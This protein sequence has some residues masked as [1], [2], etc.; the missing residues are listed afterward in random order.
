M[1]D[2]STPVLTFPADQV[3]F[4]AGF[5][6]SYYPDDIADWGLIRL[7]RA[8]PDHEPLPIRRTGK[9]ADG[10]TLFMIG[11]PLGLPAKHAPGGYV[12]ESDAADYFITNLDASGGNSGSAVFDAESHVVEGILVAGDPVDLVYRGNCLVSSV[13]ADDE[14]MGEEVIRSSQFAHL[15]PPLSGSLGYSVEFGPAGN[16][17]SLG[18]TSVPR[19][20]VRDLLPGTRYSWRVTVQG[21]CGETVGPTWT[22]TTAPA[23]GPV[24]FRRGDLVEDGKIDLSDAIGVLGVLFSGDAAECADAADADGNGVLEVTDPIVLL[25][26]LFLGGPPP[27]SPYPDCGVGAGSGGPGCDAYSGCA[28]G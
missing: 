9:V 7:D 27:A 28:S 11:H 24:P 20:T 14:C 23:V 25:Q 8:V 26:Y 6:G 4:C 19:W 21:E 15:V 16:L 22:F 2:A 13:C 1:L 5:V 18:D 12:R 17:A 3:Y 10:Q